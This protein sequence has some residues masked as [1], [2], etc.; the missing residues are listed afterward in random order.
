MMPGMDGYE[1]CRPLRADPSSA[2]VPIIMLTGMNDTASVENPRGRFS[3]EGAAATP[4]SCPT[5]LQHTPGSEGTSR[6]AQETRN[7]LLHALCERAF[8]T[9]RASLMLNELLHRQQQAQTAEDARLI[10]LRK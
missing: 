9:R 4:L 6:R 7:L 1:L 2:R 5:G 8:T 3:G 10:T